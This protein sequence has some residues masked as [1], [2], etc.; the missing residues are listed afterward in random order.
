MNLLYKFI[1]G[2]EIYD[3]SKFT[4]FLGDQRHVRNKLVFVVWCLWS[5][6]PIFSLSAT[7][8]IGGFGSFVC[9]ALIPNSKR[10]PDTASSTQQSLAKDLQLRRKFANFPAYAPTS[11]GRSAA[12]V[13]V[14]ELGL[15]LGSLLLWNVLLRLLEPR[16]I[17]FFAFTLLEARTTTTRFISS[18]ST[19][20]FRRGPTRAKFLR[21]FVHL[22]DFFD[23]YRQLVSKEPFSRGRILLHNER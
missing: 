8:K 16:K 7:H 23:L 12:F 20:C 17:Y 3:R 18:T 4:C 2:L 9:T 1:K 13:A 10:Y 22:C 5:S 21:H 6:W 11:T 19:P 14:E 15:L